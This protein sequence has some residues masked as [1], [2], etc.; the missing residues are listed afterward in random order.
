[1][2]EGFLVPSENI[3]VP[4]KFPREGVLYDDLSDEEKDSGTRWNGTRRGRF[5]TV[6]RD[7]PGIMALEV[8]VVVIKPLRYVLCVVVVLGEDD[9]LPDAIAGRHHQATL[10]QVL[11]DQIDSAFIEE[12]LVH[13]ETAQ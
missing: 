10:H 2:A 6:L 11:Q 9:G 5:L 8:R 13:R 3:I 1:M 4:L 7:H 12:P